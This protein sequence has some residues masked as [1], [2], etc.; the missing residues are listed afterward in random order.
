VAPDKTMKSLLFLSLCLFLPAG[1]RAARPPVPAANANFLSITNCWPADTRINVY[2][3]KD[4]FNESERLIL[5]QTMEG[6][7]EGLRGKEERI[8]FAFAGETRGLID[9]EHCLTISREGI[10]TSSQKRRVTVNALRQD[11]AGRLLSAWIAFERSLTGTSGLRSRMLQ[12]L[13][14]EFKTTSPQ[15]KAVSK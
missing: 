3:V 12:A 9:C 5:Q 10:S 8:S 13:E 14:Q 2:F 4:M 1:A 15:A 7:A 11:E 6:W